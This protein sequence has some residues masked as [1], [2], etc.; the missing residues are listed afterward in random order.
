M[1]NT[2]KFIKNYMLNIKE[3]FDQHHRFIMDG[4]FSS[5]FSHNDLSFGRFWL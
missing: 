5:G 2:E 3:V 4:G 1:K